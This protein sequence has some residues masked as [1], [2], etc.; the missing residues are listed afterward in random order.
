MS[1]IGKNINALAK[2]KD[3][4]QAG[5]WK[6][7]IINHIYWSAASTPNGNPEVIATKYKS[8]MNHVIDVHTGHGHEEYDT[9]AHEP[10]L[11]PPRVW[12][13]PG[14]LTF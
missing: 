12:L 10:V 4:E 7:S 5:L 13:K 14:K 1:G 3:C 11:D 9:C 8:I 2:Q 6:K